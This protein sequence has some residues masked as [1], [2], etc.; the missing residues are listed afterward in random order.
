LL[1]KAQKIELSVPIKT[2][3]MQPGKGFQ[4]IPKKNL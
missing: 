2:G 1:K 4:L 3:A